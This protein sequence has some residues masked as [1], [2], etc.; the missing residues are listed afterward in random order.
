MDKNGVMRCFENQNYQFA[1]AAKKFHLIEENTVTVFVK[2][3]QEAAKL[4]GQI[5]NQGYS[6]TLMRQ[7][8]QYC[9]NIYDRDFEKLNG[10]G[11]LRPVSGDI[12]DFYELVSEELYTEEM[13]LKM[14]IEEGIGVFW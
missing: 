11:A 12:E 5:R 14:D 6:R 8:G 2:R 13:G 3:E 1:S 9:I 10:Q 4:L 7:A